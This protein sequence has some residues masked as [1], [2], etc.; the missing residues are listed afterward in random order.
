[1]RVWRGRSAQE[2]R[3]K[4]KAQQARRDEWARLRE[5]KRPDGTLGAWDEHLVEECRDVRRKA[6]AAK[7]KVHIGRIFDFVVEKNSESL[8]ESKKK[9]K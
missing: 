7:R 9:Y 5:V 8:D 2:I 1:M 6:E 4:P 3:A